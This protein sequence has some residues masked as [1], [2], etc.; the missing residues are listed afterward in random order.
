MKYLSSKESYIGLL[1]IPICFHRT[2]VCISSEILINASPI[3]K[4]DNFPIFDQSED[5]LFHVNTE[6]NETCQK[7]KVKITSTSSLYL[8]LTVNFCSHGMSEEN[9]QAFGSKVAAVIDKISP[10]IT[11]LS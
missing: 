9:V 3:S 10:T 2:I 5:H 11:K 6:V 4:F 8:L 7:Q 1:G